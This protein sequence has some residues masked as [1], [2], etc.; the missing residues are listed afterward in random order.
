MKG[1][2]LL[3]YELVQLVLYFREVT[4]KVQRWLVAY[5]KAYTIPTKNMTQFEMNALAEKL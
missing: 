2:P 5:M 4:R 3:S 1:M